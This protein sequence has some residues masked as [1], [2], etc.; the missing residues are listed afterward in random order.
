MSMFRSFAGARLARPS[1][2]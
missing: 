1:R 2:L